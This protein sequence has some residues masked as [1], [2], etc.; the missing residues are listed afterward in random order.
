MMRVPSGRFLSRYNFIESSENPEKIFIPL[1]ISFWKGECEGETFVHKSFPL[2]SISMAKEKSAT[3]LG[4]ALYL[5]FLSLLH[6]AQATGTYGDSLGSAADRNL[7]L[8]DVGLPTS[9]GLAVG[10]R[11]V[12]TEHNAFVADAAFCH[13]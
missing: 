13:V 11:N 1:D 3:D 9:V 6:G 8:A 5:W 12:L 7:Y 2:A 10:V 4:C